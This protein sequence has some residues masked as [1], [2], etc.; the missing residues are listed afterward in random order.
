MKTPTIPSHP[1]TREKLSFQILLGTFIGIAFVYANELI[2][3]FNSGKHIFEEYPIMGLSPVTS[4]MA[5]ISISIVLGIFC[6][7]TSYIFNWIK[8]DGKNI[9]QITAI[10]YILL[11]GMIF[12]VNIALGLVPT[13]GVF[14]GFALTFT[15]IY[16]LIWLILYL[17]YRHQASL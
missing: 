2:Y 3:Y 16:A 5:A 9:I 14:L 13:F 4:T 17:Y 7:L 8:D 6:A 10:H 15:L 12:G 1:Y 11:L